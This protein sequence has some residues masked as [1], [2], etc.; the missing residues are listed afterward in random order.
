[1]NFGMAASP[2][3]V[4]SGDSQKRRL[5]NRRHVSFGP[6]VDVERTVLTALTF[7]NPP[8]MSPT[9]GYTHIVESSRPCRTI[10]ISGQLGH[11]KEGKFAGGDFERRPR[12]ALT[13]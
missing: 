2:Y 10:Y 9:R 6:L 12:S 7:K 8:A 5:A 1:M 13:I 3:L 11:T 4:W